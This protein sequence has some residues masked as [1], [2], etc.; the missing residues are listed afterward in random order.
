MHAGDRCVSSPA[1]LGESRTDIGV[2]NANQ[3][4][5]G[6]LLQIQNIGRLQALIFRPQRADSTFSHA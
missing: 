4:S 5:V 1:E 2:G 3:W 6:P